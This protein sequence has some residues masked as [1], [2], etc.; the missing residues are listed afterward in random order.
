MYKETVLHPEN[1]WWIKT[2]SPYFIKNIT[3]Q[4]SWQMTLDLSSSG[5]R[6]NVFLFVGRSVTSLWCTG[7]QLQVCHPKNNS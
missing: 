6:S 4:W 7:K 1:S 3:M 5:R 2:Q